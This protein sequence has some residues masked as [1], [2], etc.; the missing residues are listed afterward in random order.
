MC[1]N[2]RQCAHERSERIYPELFYFGHASHSRE[3]CYNQ[4]LH[5]ESLYMPSELFWGYNRSICERVEFSNRMKLYSNSKTTI[6][7]HTNYL[8][9][10]K[11]AK[12]GKNK[13]GKG[14]KQI[15][16][17]I[18]LIHNLWIKF[19]INSFENICNSTSLSKK[20]YCEIVRLNWPARCGLSVAPTRPSYC[21]LHRGYC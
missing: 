13:T 17:S 12:F 9:C 16:K 3:D 11:N 2:R 15:F 1:I 10:I 7:N 19:S 14:K 6:Y 5:Y 8:F 20:C 21:K 18:W 4:W